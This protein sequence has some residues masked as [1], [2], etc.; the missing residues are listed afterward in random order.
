MI[1]FRNFNKK[2]LKK[3][4]KRTIRSLKSYKSP[5]KNDLSFLF[6]LCVPIS[7]CLSQ[8]FIPSYSNLLMSKFHLIGQNI[9]TSLSPLIHNFLFG[10][11]GLSASGYHYSLY[12]HEN[13][14]LSLD[15]MIRE[16]VGGISITIPFKQ[17]YMPEIKNG[18]L[19]N[20]TVIGN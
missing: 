11:K 14:L 16:N 17:G 1:S 3:M 7:R 8:F 9:K 4:M 18:K 10:L 13:Y 15:E 6:Y 19:R 2:S 20:G 5:N 12:P